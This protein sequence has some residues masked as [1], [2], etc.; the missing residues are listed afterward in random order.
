[1]AKQKLIENVLVPSRLFE[2]VDTPL[3]EEAVGDKTYDILAV[4]RFP[5]TR[6]GQENLNGRI[7][8]YFLWDRIFGMNIVTVSLVNHPEDDGDPARIWAVMKNAGY[9]KDRT[10]GMVDCYIINNEYGKTAMGVLAAGGD[11]G[12]SSCGVGDF[13]VDGKTVTAERNSIWAVA[14]I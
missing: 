2:K 5:F 6:P 11:I 13:D 3:H 14:S 12:L 9:N 4:Y 8:S 7:Y 1:M 10:L